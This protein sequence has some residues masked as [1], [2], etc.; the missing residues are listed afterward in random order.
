MT[1][2]L[3]DLGRRLR[4][5]DGAMLRMLTADFRPEDWMRRPGAD[6]G[7]SP[8]WIVA[9]LA[10]SRRR[11]R[12]K[13]GDAVPEESWERLVATGHKP[14]PVHELPPVEV[15][16]ADFGESGGVLE[17]LLATL[18]EDEASAPWGSEFPDG[19]KSLSG[20]LHFFHFHESYHLGQ[21]G[22]IRRL[23]GKPGFV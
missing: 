5:N 19:S 22:L 4:F 8:H 18:T 11:V 17:R 10:A 14:E 6:G 1:A 12:R 2:V 9:H 13:L 15:L 23:C 3:T 21:L 20:G 7:N 16:L